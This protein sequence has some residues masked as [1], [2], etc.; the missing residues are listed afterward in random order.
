MDRIKIPFGC[1][2]PY[3]IH[4]NLASFMVAFRWFLSLNLLGCPALHVKAFT[5]HPSHATLNDYSFTAGPRLTAKTGRF[6]RARY[7]Q[8]FV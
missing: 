4:T 2:N 7:A 5:P 8:S 6:Y 1:A 3:Q